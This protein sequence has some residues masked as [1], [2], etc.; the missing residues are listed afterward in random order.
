MTDSTKSTLADPARIPRSVERTARFQLGYGLCRDTD[1][2]V[3]MFAEQTQARC[4][5]QMPAGLRMVF[6]RSIGFKTIVLMS[7]P[8]STVRE[9]STSGLARAHSFL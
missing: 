6:K 4:A 5:Y 8:C 1:R 9:T 7:A 3:D 2:R